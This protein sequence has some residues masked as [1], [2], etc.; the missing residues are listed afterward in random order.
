MNNIV[1][2]I[3]NNKIIVV[4]NCSYE[5]F[6]EY[7]SQGYEICGDTPLVPAQH[8][9]YRHMREIYN[10]VNKKYKFESVGKLA[11]KEIIVGN[12]IKKGFTI[13]ENLTINEIGLNRGYSDLSIKQYISE[14]YISKKTLKDFMNSDEIFFDNVY[15]MDIYKLITRKFNL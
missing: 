1:K 3:K 14:N 6:K 4:A 8:Y 13:L 5:S 7:I 11:D 10:E 12:E 9:V 15:G 2:F